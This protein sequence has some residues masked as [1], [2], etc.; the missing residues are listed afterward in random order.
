[1]LHLIVMTLGTVLLY[2]FIF[3][4]VIYVLW[5]IISKSRIRKYENDIIFLESCVRNFVITP[6]NQMMLEESFDNIFKNNQDAGRTKEI[7]DEFTQKYYK[8][9]YSGKI[10][11]AEKQLN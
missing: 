1:M 2:S 5:K 11:E 3:M 10:I 6:R 7:W 8:P 9:A 4:F